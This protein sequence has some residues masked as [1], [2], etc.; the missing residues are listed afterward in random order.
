MA[1][2]NYPIMQSEKDVYE[3]LQEIIRIR[4]DEDR[5]SDLAQESTLNRGIFYGDNIQVVTTS[6]ALGETDYHVECNAT[7]GPIT[8]TLTSNPQ[9]RQKQSVAKV[10]AGGNAVTVSASI[11]GGSSDT[12]SSQY[13]VQEYMYI[14]AQD[15][16]RKL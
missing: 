6:T 2:K 15:E 10:D 7:S 8:I 5:Q 16:W 1:I 11:N 9:D 12:L 4:N 13:D 14:A 3:T